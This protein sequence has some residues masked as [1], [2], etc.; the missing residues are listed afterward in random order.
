MKVSGGENVLT[1]TGI[2]ATRR[3]GSISVNSIPRV[4]ASAVAAASASQVW[5]ACERNPMASGPELEREGPLEIRG[6]PGYFFEGGRRL[7]LST[8]TATVVIFATGRDSALSAANAL[9]GINNQVAARALALRQALNRAR[10]SGGR[11]QG[12]LFLFVAT[13]GA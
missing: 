4:A 11:P 3:L 5:A 8:G 10:G 13:T 2:V 6:V 9:E 1:A 12:R 7:E